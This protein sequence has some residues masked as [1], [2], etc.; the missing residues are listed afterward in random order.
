[1]E[2][3]GRSKEKAD[4]PGST[5]PSTDGGRV[6]QIIAETEVKAKSS[7]EAAGMSAEDNHSVRPS[8]RPSARTADDE[9]EIAKMC[10]HRRI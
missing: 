10:T 7:H 8:E 5:A 6:K 2:R 9:E 3:R 1:M 4:G